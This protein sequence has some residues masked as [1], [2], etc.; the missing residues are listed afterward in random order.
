V[1]GFLPPRANRRQDRLS[2][3]SATNIGKYIAGASTEGLL[4]KSVET[5]LS[6]FAE[7]S[8]DYHD[9]PY[10]FFG[11]LARYRGDRSEALLQYERCIEMARDEWPSSWAR[12]R[13]EQMSSAEMPAE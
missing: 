2:V 4:V 10:F 9:D 12:Y 3:I 5:L 1:I 7:G 6:R 11:E 13:I 8:L